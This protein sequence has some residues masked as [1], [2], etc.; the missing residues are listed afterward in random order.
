M[1][2]RRFDIVTH[3]KG[4][5][6]K[7]YDTSVLKKFLEYMLKTNELVEKLEESVE[8]DDSDEDCDCENTDDEVKK[9]N[10]IRRDI[11]NM[12]EWAFGIKST[13]AVK[14]SSFS[15]KWRELHPN[16]PDLF[17]PDSITKETIFTIILYQILPYW[18]SH[19]KKEKSGESL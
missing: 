5:K 13:D 12:M 9:M 15:K 7:E 3:K 19:K 8:E 14:Q 4:K 2:L 16:L 18:V 10:E 11:A 6:M 17:L 1:P